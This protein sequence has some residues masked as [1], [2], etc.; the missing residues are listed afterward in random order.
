MDAFGWINLVLLVIMLIGY[1]YHKGTYNPFKA[2]WDDITKSK[3]G[4]KQ[5]ALSQSPNSFLIPPKNEITRPK[6]ATAAS[7]PVS[8][9]TIRTTIS[10]PCPL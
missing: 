5:A 2:L 8:R 3:Q 7:K 10:F 6:I 9:L 4:F 1:A